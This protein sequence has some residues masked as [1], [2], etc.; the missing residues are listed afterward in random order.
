MR[1][2]LKLRM[3]RRQMLSLSR[4]TSGNFQKEG[5]LRVGRQERALTDRFCRLRGNL[6]FIMKKQ[7]GELD[8]VLLLERCEVLKT[9]EDNR[10]LAVSFESGDPPFFLQF[11]GSAECH[12]WLMALRDANTEALSQRI[13]HLSNLINRH[14]AGETKRTQD[15]RGAG[16][17]ASAAAAA[18][19]SPLHLTVDCHVV[20]AVAARVH[21]QVSVIDIHSHAVRKHCCTEIVKAPD[22]SVFRTSVCFRGNYPIYL[23][24]RI[25]VTV[26]HA[27][28][29]MTHTTAQLNSA[30]KL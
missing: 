3:N 25:K 27:K 5:T 6:L 18:K 7:D 19:V 14:T 17:A 24:S 16:G 21:I 9:P 28:E 2:S 4:E 30:A 1:R 29:P 15:D 20:V 23:D 26:H 13:T 8:E 22:D 10:R 12:S 11:G